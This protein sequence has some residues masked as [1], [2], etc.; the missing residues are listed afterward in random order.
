[1]TT[2]RDILDQ[3]RI[4]AVA[5]IHG[6]LPEMCPCDLTVICGDIFP[7][8]MD[9]DHEAQ[10]VWFKN[11]FI[12]WMELIPSERVILI[13]GNHDYWIEENNQ[14]LLTEFAP[15]V[16]RKLVYLCDSG[17]AFSGLQIYGTPWVPAPAHN[18]AFSMAEEQLAEVYALIPSELDLLLTHTIPYG[19]NGL[20]ATDY[21]QH[22]WGSAELLKAVEARHIRYLI[23]G[24]IHASMNV[25]TR[26]EWG[27]H[28]TMM[29]NVACCDNHKNPLRYPITI[30]VSMN[31]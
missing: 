2:V 3:I 13:G 30:A 28:Q 19:C 22:L 20:D 29:Y 14:M 15:S 9:K 25:M 21:D 1:M 6:H 27:N 4:T 18:K 5:D 10:G 24:H 7:G 16:G 23:G 17:M 8:E 12:P 31:C 11:A 26:K